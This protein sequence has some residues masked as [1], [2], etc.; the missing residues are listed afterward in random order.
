MPTHA[1]PYII[2][3]ERTFEIHMYIAVCSAM[4]CQGC[5]WMSSDQGILSNFKRKAYSIDLKAIVK[6]FWCIQCS[7]GASVKLHYEYSVA[8]L[9]KIFEC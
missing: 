6:T 1:M 4:P 2:E 9:Y 7:C 5:L 3:L 8:R